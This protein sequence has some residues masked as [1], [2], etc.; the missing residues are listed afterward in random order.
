M[1]RYLN[2]FGCLSIYLSF[3]L[4]LLL[5]LT[6]SHVSLS[7]SPPCLSHILSHFL[8]PMFLYPTLSY[9]LPDFSP[10]F[11]HSPLP[12]IFSS[13]LSPPP[14]LITVRLSFSLPLFLPRICLLLSLSLSLSLSLPFFLTLSIYLSASASSCI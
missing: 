7:L 8:Y 12:P 3:S 14:S 4:N 1:H 11:S 5:S 13:L 10:S 9:S 6:L 2:L